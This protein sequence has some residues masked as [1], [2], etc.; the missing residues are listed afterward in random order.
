MDSSS[1]E[2][3]L[4]ASSKN[5]FNV[6]TLIRSLTAWI[7]Q[8][9]Q[10]QHLVVR[11]LFY[12]LAD[13]QI[14]AAFLETVSFETMDDVLPGSTEKNKISNI[15]KCIQFAVDKYGMERN[16]QRW[17]AEGIVQKDIAST[18]SFLVDLSHYVACPLA[19][20]SNVTIA[21]IH[22]DKIDSGVK[23]K[24]TLHHITGDESQYNDKA[25]AVN[26]D[27]IDSGKDN[28]NEDSDV[29][30]NME[31]NQD[32]IAEIKELLIDFCNKHL[33]EMNIAIND[34]ED[35]SN[36]VYIIWLIGLIKNIF[37][38]SY[39]Y[40]EEPSSYTDKVDNVN[41]I[42]FLLNN[43]G[44]NCSKIKPND[45]VKGDKKTILRCLYILFSLVELDENAPAS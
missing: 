42:I 14:L 39:Q 31:E 17:T 6:K 11:D 38:P 9:L 8:T 21:V 2:Y 35:F 19:I 13:G 16:P 43:L 1:K 44:I 26:L 10:K 23:N 24:T 12:D 4:H 29:F 37:I 45:F 34:L 25:G 5:D 7:N 18:L 20:P 22:Q 30:D 36:G 33:Q 27:Y 15:N 40:K 28:S 3:Q 32:K 41:F